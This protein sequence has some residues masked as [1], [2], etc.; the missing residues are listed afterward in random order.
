MV[1][2]YVGKILSILALIG[3][4][5]WFVDSIDFCEE[6]G[7][8]IN[9][10]ENMFLEYPQVKDV[11]TIAESC[12][13]SVEDCLIEIGKKKILKKVEQKAEESSK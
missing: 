6:T 4:L 5:F 2:Y 1:W 10:L 13:N 12:D 3:T 7:F 8:G 11:T 9:C